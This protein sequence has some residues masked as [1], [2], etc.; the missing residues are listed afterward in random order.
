MRGNSGHRRRSWRAGELGGAFWNNKPLYQMTWF[1]WASDFV[2]RWRTSE[3]AERSARDK[4]TPNAI[5]A[6]EA[7]HEEAHRRQSG[8]VGVEHILLGL[9]GLKRGVANGTLLAMGIDLNA[10]YLEAAKVAG[11]GNTEAFA[12]R[13]PFT[14]RSKKVLQDA[15]HHSR[16]LGHHYIGTEHVL[17]ALLAERE[18]LAAKVFKNLKLDA[19]LL[20]KELLKTISS[21]VSD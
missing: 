17:L 13:I 21:P 14:P 2:S 9:V 3:A 5:A 16:R 19:D 1:D 4:F 7:A 6:L 18:G 8:F 15:F 11:V 20:L 12:Q 10:V